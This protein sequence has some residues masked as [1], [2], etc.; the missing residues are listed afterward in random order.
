[1]PPD[2]ICLH[3]KSTLSQAPSCSE[4][5]TLSYRETGSRK[6]LDIPKPELT[7][8]I[9]IGQILFHI[10]IY[11]EIYKIYIN[12]CLPCQGSLANLSPEPFRDHQQ[13]EFV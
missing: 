4:Y 1:M 2:A 6:R 13:V 8:A 11:I 10:H 7:N 9:E 12:I 5:E 3:S